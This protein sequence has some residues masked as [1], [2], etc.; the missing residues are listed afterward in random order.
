SLGFAQSD[1]ANLIVLV[2]NASPNS[3]D[4]FADRISINPL[5]GPAFGNNEQATKE[6]GEPDHAGK[7]GGKSIWYTWHAS[8]SGMI[9]LSTKGSSF[10]TL[11]AV[12]TGN[13]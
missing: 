13:V 1:K 5:L 7:Q 4:N 12:Y 2:G 6:A 9:S 8:F 3:A 10:D 11:L